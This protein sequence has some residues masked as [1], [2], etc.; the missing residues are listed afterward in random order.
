MIA[1]VQLKVCGLT[2]A[3]DA[4]RAERCGADCFGFILYPGSPRFVSVDRFRAIAPSLPPRRTVAVSVEPSLDDL[5]AQRDAGFDFFQIHFRPG[6]G[7]ARL[8][9][10]SLAAGAGRL[11]LAPRLPPGAE[12]APAWPALAD[13]FL[14]DAYSANKFGGT[15]RTGDWPAFARRQAAHP[16][17]TWIL[18]GGLAP[19][20][21]G[22]ALRAT[23]ARFVDVNSGVESA[24]GVKDPEKLKAFAEALRRGRAASGPA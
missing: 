2:S 24:P 23:G 4:E 6:E 14:L 18:S 22:D 8:A 16:E 3:L 20:N 12:I 11:W 7:E 17:R 13:A 10:W 15:G 1:G 5:E 19:A 9:A 21:I